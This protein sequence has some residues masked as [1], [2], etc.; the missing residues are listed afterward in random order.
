MVYIINL[1]CP[2]NVYVPRYRHLSCS[3][4]DVNI[5]ATCYSHGKDSGLVVRDWGP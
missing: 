3:P 5:I 4:T 1:L 2:Y